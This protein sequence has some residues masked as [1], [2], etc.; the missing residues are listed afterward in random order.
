MRMRGR[1]AAA[2]EVLAISIFAGI[3]Q[4]RMRED[5]VKADGAAH[6]QSLGKYCMGEGRSSGGDFVPLLGHTIR[7]YES[8]ARLYISH[9]LRAGRISTRQ[10]LVAVPE[11]DF[12]YAYSAILRSSNVRLEHHE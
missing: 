9:A 11:K 2:Q 5:Q 3:A 1:T 8:R 7:S 10:P 4:V 6:L 12:R